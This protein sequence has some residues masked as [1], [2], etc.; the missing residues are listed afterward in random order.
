VSAAKKSWHH[1]AIAFAA[2]CLALFCLPAARSLRATQTASITVHLLNAESG[3][4]LR[5]VPISIESWN[6]P[7]NGKPDRPFPLGIVKTFTDR[8]GLLSFQLPAPTPEYVGFSIGGPQQ[9]W[10][11]SPSIFPVKEALENGIVAQFD[12]KRPECGKLRIKVSAPSAGE[13][14]IYE[15][16]FSRWDWFRQEMP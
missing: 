5:K 11:C 13:I 7:P 1:F 14:V 4:P 8:N 2:C 3:K 6:G 9:F 10:G 12:E 16:V 15:R